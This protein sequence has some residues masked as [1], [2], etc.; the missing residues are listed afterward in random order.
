M[1]V[2]ENQ[3]SSVRGVHYVKRHESTKR[4][5]VYYFDSAASRLK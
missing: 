4:L 3:D 1:M 2:S 5:I